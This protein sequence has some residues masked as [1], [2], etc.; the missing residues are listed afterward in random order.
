MNPRPKHFSMIREFH[1]ADLFTLGNAACGTASI[2]FAMNFMGSHA[3]TDFFIAAALAPAAFVFDVIDGRV[4]W[5]RKI[6]LERQLEMSWPEVHKGCRIREADQALTV[7]A[8]VDSE[9]YLALV[10]VKKPKPAL[11]KSMFVRS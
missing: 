5:Q 9:P 2:F 1:L 3:L 10:N 7:K 8:A 11:W 4:T 6:A